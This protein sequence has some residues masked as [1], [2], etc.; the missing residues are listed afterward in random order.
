M[1]S[2]FSVLINVF[3]VV[4]VSQKNANAAITKSDHDY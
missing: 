3:T 2:N 4:I 1:W